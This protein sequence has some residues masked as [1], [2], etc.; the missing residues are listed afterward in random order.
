MSA[1]N[2]SLW[3]REGGS[4]DQQIQLATLAPLHVED[5]TLTLQI[6]W[7]RLIQAAASD[8]AERANLIFPALFNYWHYVERLLP[9][10]AAG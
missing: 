7:R 2:A 6:Y 8:L 10:D 4:T 9:A 5:Q 1:R 3:S